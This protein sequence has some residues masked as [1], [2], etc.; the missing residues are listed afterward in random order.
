MISNRTKISIFFL[1]ISI[2]SSCAFMPLDLYHF[3]INKVFYINLSK[4]NFLR[5]IKVL[6]S[7]FGFRII[8]LYHLVRRILSLAVSPDLSSRIFAISSSHVARILKRIWIWKKFEISESPRWLTSTLLQFTASPRYC[9][10]WWFIDFYIAINALWGFINLYKV[11]QRY[12]FGLVLSLVDDVI[13]RWVRRSYTIL[14][15]GNIDSVK[16]SLP[17]TL[18]FITCCS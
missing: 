12:L 5:P 9:F 15:E 11:L 3:T 2:T 1:S 16:K 13:A 17:F 6:W 18:V 8:S 7:N 10:T 4:W 14:L